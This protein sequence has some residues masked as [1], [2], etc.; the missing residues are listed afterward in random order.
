MRTIVRISFTNTPTLDEPTPIA[1]SRECSSLTT[2]IGQFG[3]VE[4]IY[5]KP[6]EPVGPIRAQNPWI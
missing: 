2:L 5:G 6:V 4:R 1:N 3:A